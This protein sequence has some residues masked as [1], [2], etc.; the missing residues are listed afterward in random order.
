MVVDLNKQVES[1]VTRNK[2]VEHQEVDH[3][4]YDFRYLVASSRGQPFRGGEKVLFTTKEI[5]DLYDLPNDPDVYP[6][7]RLIAD[8]RER[9]SKKIIKL[10][11]WL[12]ANW[13]R[14][15]TG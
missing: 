11:A 2:A 7:Q 8:P 6:G 12:V 10:I 1:V 9:D 3:L 15:P 5:D 13:M 4:R 14:M